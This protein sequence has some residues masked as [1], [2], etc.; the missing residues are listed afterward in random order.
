MPDQVRHDGTFGVP[1]N[2]NSRVRYLLW[3][4]LVTLAVSIFFP[5]DTLE[6]TNKR[7]G[8]VILRWIVSTDDQ[9]VYR[10][11]HSVEKTPVEAQFSIEDDQSMRLTET[12]FPSYGAG[13]PN[14]V[15]E[16]T[17]TSGWITL[18]SSQK[19][20]SFSTYFSSINHP[21]VVI[22]NRKWEIESL[23]KDGDILALT[24]KTRP[25]WM[26]IPTVLSNRTVPNQ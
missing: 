21:S 22:H 2:Q 12:R 16:K 11:I 10:Y 3:I 1:L 25:L 18:S 23:F 17:H 24:V 8:Q 7:T 20:E 14:A 4:G 13:L 9:V 5:I 19:M 26:I 6:L 15:G